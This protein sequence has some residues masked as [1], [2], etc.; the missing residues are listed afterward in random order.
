MLF[1]RMAA[2]ASDSY[3]GSISVVCLSLGQNRSRW[4]LRG[5]FIWA[6]GSIIRWDQDRGGDKMAAMRPFVKILWPLI[7]IIITF[8]T[9]C[10][11]AVFNVFIA[12]CQSAY[13]FAGRITLTVMDRFS[14]NM[15]NSYTMNSW[16]KSWLNFGGDPEH[17]LDILLSYALYQ[18]T[19]F[20]MTFNDPK[21]PQTTPFPNFVS[22]FIS[23]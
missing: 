20:P 7:I 17:I 4:C 10:R 5:W 18:T 13:L 2:I 14:W 6:Q 12:L 21:Y 1:G 16:V 11:R 22:P 3:I 23:S 9:F 8:A 15:G 19:L